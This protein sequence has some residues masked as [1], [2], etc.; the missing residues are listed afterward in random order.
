M[1]QIKVWVL[2]NGLASGITGP[3]DVL[4]AANAIWAYQNK[5]KAEPL[6]EW[7]LESLDGKPVRTASGLTLNV[8]GPI[9]PRTAADALLLPGIF[10][11]NGVAFFLKALESYQPLLPALRKLHER[12]T[13]IAANCSAGFL[14]AESG[15]LDHRQA[16]TH[17]YLAKAFQQRYP[18]VDLRPQEVITEHDR[19]ICSGAATAYLNLALRL[20]EKFAGANLAAATAKMLLIDANR[21]SQASFKSLTVQDHLPHADAL[22]VKAQRWMEKRLPQSFRL[23]DLARAMAVSERT[24][25]RRF[26][27]ALGDT[28]VGYL[29]TMKIELAKRLLETTALSVD[30][31]SDR[32]GYADLSSFRRLFKRETGLSPRDYQQR[33]ARRHRSRTLTADDISPRA[34]V[35]R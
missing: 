6:F 28:P 10:L 35:S 19:L 25:I 11:G 33:F 23:A 31:I 24:V 9:N 7:R 12:G 4:V 14:L 32:I 16:T 18:L 21:V 26:K 2:D 1:R 5:D 34:R 13:V 29:Q 8:D 22:V 17:W 15:L 27:Q 3:I 20:V 30:A